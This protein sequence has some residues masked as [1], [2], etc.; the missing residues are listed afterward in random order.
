MTTCISI[1]YLSLLWYA[2][3]GSRFDPLALSDKR[4]PRRIYDLPGS[5]ISRIGELQIIREIFLRI[6]LT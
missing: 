4:R 2:C 5:M 6:C 1:M 3:M